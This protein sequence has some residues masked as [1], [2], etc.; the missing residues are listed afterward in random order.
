MT[1]TIGFIG[2]GDMGGP[3]ARRL[4]DAGYPLIV[5][6]ISEASLEP[7]LAA[8]AVKAADAEEV[9]SKAETV[10]ICLNSLNA[11][12]EVAAAAAR[13]SLIRTFIDLS[14]TGP[15]FAREVREIFAG[16]EVSMLDCP[17]SGAMKGAEEGTL[18]LMISGDEPVFQSVRPMFEAIGK[19]LF[20]LGNTPGGGQMM[21]LVN[22][23]LSSMASVGTSEALVL[24]VKAGLDAKTML[25]V[26]NVSTGRNNASS[27]KMP[28][29]V[30]KRRFHTGGRMTITSKDISL[31]LEEAERLGVPM[32]IGE[33]TKAL[34]DRAIE[35]GHA[36][37]RS[38]AVIKVIEAQ[39]GVVVGKAE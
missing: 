24:G 1:E 38:S 27:V 28:E 8:G 3:M 11:I 30:L 33:V 25:D 34:F 31:C 10:M 22:N 21:K 9:A 5:H 4:L 39:A 16:T 18:S 13:G 36:A 19:N 14:T 17:V 12:R 35:E 20:Y 2:V 32:R 6:D 15:T 26:I 23:Y 29:G 37:E 7:I